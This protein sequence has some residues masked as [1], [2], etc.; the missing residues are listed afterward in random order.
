MENTIEDQKS[1]TSYASNRGTISMFKRVKTAKK[2]S[3]T[4]TQ[5]SETS[6]LYYDLDDKSIISFDNMVKKNECIKF[7]SEIRRSSPEKTN[8][9]ID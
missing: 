9:C 3:F 2:L 1:T 7:E 8:N 4:P 5:A 6:E